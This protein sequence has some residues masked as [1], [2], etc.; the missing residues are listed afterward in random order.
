MEKVAVCKEIVPHKT[1]KPQSV[2]LYFCWFADEMIKIS[3]SLFKCLQ[4]EAG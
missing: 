4:A 3:V 1:L 2:I